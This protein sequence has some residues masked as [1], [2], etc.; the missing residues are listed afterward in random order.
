MKK[1]EKS[2]SEADFHVWLTEQLPLLEA[3]QYRRND[4]RVVAVHLLPLLQYDPSYWQAASYLNT[5]AGS[6][7]ETFRAFLYVTVGTGISHCFVLEGRPFAGARGNAL[8][9]ASSPYTVYDEAKPKRY[10]PLENFSLAPALVQRYNNLTGRTLTQGT[11]VD[12]GAENGDETARF[13]LES[14]GAA[15]GVGV[16]WLVNT[17]DPHAVIV[18]GGLGVAGGLY[19]QTFEK[20]T[21]EHIWGQSSRSLPL[22]RALLDVDA[23]LIGAAVSVL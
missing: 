2:V 1:L 4:N 6:E 8:L 9:F 3:D 14:A 12:I 20:I 11:Y 22:R 18:G 17:L 7:D 23:G 19:W 10:V 5:W 16:G 21:R 13:V 15:L